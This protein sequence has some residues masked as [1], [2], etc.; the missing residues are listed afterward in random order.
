MDI[1]WDDPKVSSR[2]GSYTKVCQNPS[3]SAMCMCIYIY[4]GR[5]RESERER[6]RESATQLIKTTP[7]KKLKVAL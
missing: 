3:A 2:K 5:K 1:P 7:T 4:I 6:E